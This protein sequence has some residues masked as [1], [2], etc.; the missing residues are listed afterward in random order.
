MANA[1]TLRHNLI[2]ATPEE[3]KHA[4]ITQDLK[5]LSYL[6]FNVVVIRVPRCNFLSETI[7][8]SAKREL[9]I[10]CFSLKL[11]DTG[12]DIGSPS[13]SA[14]DIR[15]QKKCIAASRL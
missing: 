2:S 7:V 9:P 3:P 15:L 4:A 13:T 12:K 5:L 14:P 10:P 11:M 1:E 8:E 6:G